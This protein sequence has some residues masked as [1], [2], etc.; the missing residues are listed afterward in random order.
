ME[1]GSGDD[2]W[3][4]GLEEGQLFTGSGAELGS[5]DDWWP[6]GL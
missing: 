2:W 4:G 5:G 3:P 1:L 6:G